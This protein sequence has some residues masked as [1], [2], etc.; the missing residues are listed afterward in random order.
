[1]RVAH[2][3]ESQPRDRELHGNLWQTIRAA[4]CAASHNRH[5][6]DKRSF[7]REG[8]CLARSRDAERATTHTTCGGDDPTSGCTSDGL[9]QTLCRLAPEATVRLAAGLES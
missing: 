5:I 9:E 8:V 7:E 6:S 4:L 1:M 2:H 3:S